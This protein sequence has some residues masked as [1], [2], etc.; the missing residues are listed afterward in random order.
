MKSSLHKLRL[1]RDVADVIRGLHPRIKR[2]LR[3]AL[4]QVLADPRTGK[5]L[6]D[7]LAGLWSLRV[8][9]F[10]LIYRLGGKTVD[11]VAFGP[12]DRIYEETYRLIASAAKKER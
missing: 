8:G 5:T 4:E 9:K 10:R 7:E 2:K 1:P 6:K 12:R 11:V 3:A